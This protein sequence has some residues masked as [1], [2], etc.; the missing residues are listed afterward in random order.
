MKFEGN[1]KF[2]DVASLKFLMEE[3]LA[4]VAPLPRSHHWFQ[5]PQ[6]QV[7]KQY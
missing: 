6:A 2:P 7:I 5:M 3:E 1:G 4:D